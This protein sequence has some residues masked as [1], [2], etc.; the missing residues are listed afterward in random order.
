MPSESRAGCDCRLTPKWGRL[1]QATLQGSSPGLSRLGVAGASAWSFGVGLEARGGQGSPDSQRNL[2]E[3]ATCTPHTISWSAGK[4]VSS[5]CWSPPQGRK[6]PFTPQDAPSPRSSGRRLPL[7]FPI[8]FFFF[9]KSKSSLSR[10]K[11]AGSHARGGG[12]ATIGDQG[13]KGGGVSGGWS[14]GEGIPMVEAKE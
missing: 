10:L 14:L 13:W 12:S 5:R 1:P 2:V 8:F 7:I 3:R 9:W 6:R 11:R 4:I